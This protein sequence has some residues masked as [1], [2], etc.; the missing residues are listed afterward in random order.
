MRRLDWDV[1][2]LRCFLQR[3]F[4][5]GRYLTSSLAITSSAS[6]ANCRL[7][8]QSAI[9]SWRKRFTNNQTVLDGQPTQPSK[10]GVSV[11]HL[12]ADLHGRKGEARTIGQIGQWFGNDAKNRP[13]AD[14]QRRSAN[15]A[16]WS[17]CRPATAQCLQGHQGLRNQQTRRRGEC[18]QQCRTVWRRCGPIVVGLLCQ[19]LLVTEFV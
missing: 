17:V 11:E 15:A 6:D 3:S 2:A 1:F 13:S 8:N 7:V 10:R 14:S 9:M 4:S 5:A 19:W 18:G 16:V 12:L